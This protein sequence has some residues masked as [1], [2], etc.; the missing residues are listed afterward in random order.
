VIDAPG[1]ARELDRKLTSLTDELGRWRAAAG[2]KQPLARHHTQLEAVTGTLDAA[3][4]ELKA[5]L[6]GADQGLWILERAGAI[7][8]RI[9]DLHR[10]WGFFRDKF[11]LRYLPW[12]RD[13]LIAADDMAWA[14][15]SPAQERIPETR[16]REPPLVFFSGGSSP[17][18]MPRGSPYVVE[19][20]PDGGMREPEFE[21][22]VRV[23]P[24][25]LIGMPWFQ[26]EHLPD[27]PLIGHEVGH[28][29]E[30]D[31]Q[32]REPVA[33]VIEAAV[34]AEHAPAWK[35]WADEVFADVFGVL[36]CGPGFV[37][38]LAAALAGHPR[39]VEG[40]D[41][42]PED[43][44][45]YPTRTLRVLLAAATLELLKV[46]SSG[47]IAADWRRAYPEHQL[48]AYESDVG[49]VAEAV[50]KGPYPPLGKDARL[51]TLMPFSS[52]DEGHA[53]RAAERLAGGL[54][55]DVGG[56]RHAVAGARLAYDERRQEYIGNGGSAAL[57]QWIAGVPFDGVRAAGGADT[58]DEGVR[59][60]RDQTAGQALSDLISRAAERD[61][62][63]EATGVPA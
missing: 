4:S 7:D 12:L 26:V 33:E 45:E 61:D 19:P 42:G 47:P 38:A 63:Q 14:C 6:V 10:L 58:P 56:I 32:L 60:T 8:R 43:W 41:A 21:E 49:D 27:A 53:L 52:E 35:A 48:A 5:E 55:P 37:R 57:L 28:A 3:A 54:A 30:L 29:V 39:I 46:N 13:A 44:G 17:F 40:E 16:K 15:Y 18:L 2:E 59:A 22:A 20:L 9:L 62:R 25:P 34:P 11:A 36:C 51:D 50:L 24:M 23:I 1:T 31:L